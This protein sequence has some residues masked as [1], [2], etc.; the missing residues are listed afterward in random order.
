M[1]WTLDQDLPTDPVQVHVYVDGVMRA[2][3]TA[4]RPR[5]DIGLAYPDAGVYHGWQ[6]AAIPATSGVHNVCAY[7]IN[8]HGGSSNPQLACRSVTVP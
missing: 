3:V 2:S 1:G 4:N 8:I 7:G 6:T 5:A